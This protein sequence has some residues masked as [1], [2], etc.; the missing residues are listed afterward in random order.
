MSVVGIRALKQNASAVVAE[1]A[2]GELVTI[3]DRGR[4]VA[5]WF[6]WLPA[7]SKLCWRP[8]GLVP[9]CGVSRI[10]HDPPVGAGVAQLCL[11]NWRRCVRLSGP[12]RVLSRYLC[13]GEAGRCR[14]GLNGTS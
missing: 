11:T 8:S 5:R 1:A 4:P 13:S 14:E 12:R 10:C 9:R 6:A 3:T 2:S 7:V